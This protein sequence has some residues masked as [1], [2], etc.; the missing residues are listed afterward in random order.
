MPAT[1]L[2]VFR[3]PSSVAFRRVFVRC[4]ATARP[5]A[6]WSEAK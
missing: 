5:K 3:S 2:A 1:H 6:L 4:Q